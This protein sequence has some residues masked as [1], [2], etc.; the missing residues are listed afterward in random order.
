MDPFRKKLQIVFQ[1]PHSSLNPAI[2]IFGSWEEPLKKYG[3]KSRNERRKIIG[4]L[5]EAVNMRREYMDRYPHEFSGGQRQR[6]GIAR[7]LCIGPEIIVCD[8]AV[9]ALDVSIQAQVLQLLM[10]LR[11]ERNLTYLFITHDLSV[12]E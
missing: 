5:L 9:S 3:V 1:D 7:A 4:D 11:K 10:K 12:T 8:E 6:I 2:T